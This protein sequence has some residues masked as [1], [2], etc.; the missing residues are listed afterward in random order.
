VILADLVS[1]LQSLDLDTVA[2]AELAGQGAQLADLVRTALST[3]PGGPHDHPWR[4]TGALHDSIVNDADG[5]EAVV[6]STS[7]TALFQ[8]HGT[9]TM[10]PRP[11]FTP[12][13]A[14][15]GETIAHAIAAALTQAIRSA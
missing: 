1:R 10:P 11:T 3:L 8:E 7:E 4:Q 9:A 15:H 13:A 12:V 5:D 2:R 14:E 6:A